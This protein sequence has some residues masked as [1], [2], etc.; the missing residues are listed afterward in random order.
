MYYVYIWKEATDLSV[1]W[2]L[3]QPRSQPK[4]RKLRSAPR[5]PARNIIW[6]QKKALQGQTNFSSYQYSRDSNLAGEMDSSKKCS[7][8]HFLTFCCQKFAGRC[9]RLLESK[10]VPEPDERW[11][12]RA[13]GLSQVKMLDSCSARQTYFIGLLG[14]LLLSASGNFARNFCVT[15][16]SHYRTNIGAIL[17]FF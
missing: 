8:F 5:F 6:E 4:E 13:A 2:A 9:C 14:L 1:L 7:F 3:N 10:K 16:T 11:R 15:L 17:N 12:E